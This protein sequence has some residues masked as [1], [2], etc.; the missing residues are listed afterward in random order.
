MRC[1]DD[2]FIA[3]VTIP[4]GTTVRAGHRFVKTWEIQNTGLVAWHG[5]FLTRQ[6]LNTGPGL[7]DSVPRVA[8]PATLPGQDVQISVTFTAP[9]LPGSC[10]TD[11]KMTDA[12]GR[13]YFPDRA[14]LYIVVN[15]T[16]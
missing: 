2:R 3:D 13:L 4:D 15:V 1:D 9:S 8:I 10:R 7:C 5:R 11:W 12:D 6:G 14:G 16:G